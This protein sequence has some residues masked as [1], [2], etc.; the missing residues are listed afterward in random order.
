MGKVKRN[1]DD[2]GQGDRVPATASSPALATW[3]PLDGCKSL[4]D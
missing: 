4:F 3:L 2:I 1:E